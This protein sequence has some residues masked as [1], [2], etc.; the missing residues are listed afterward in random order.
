M[1]RFEQMHPIVSFIY[2]M[3]AIFITMFTNNP[4]ITITSFIGSIL[5]DISLRG[6]KKSIIG[7][8]KLLPIMLLVVILNPVFNSRGVTILFY[9]NGNPFTLEALLYGANAAVMIFGVINWFR[10]YS[11]VFTSDKF[12]YLFGK[13][14]PKFSLV[15]ALVMSFIPRFS[16]K[17]K[18]IDEAQKALGVYQSKSFTDRLR[19]RFRIL[20]ILIT[21]S[22]ETSIETADSMKA[23]GY[24]LFGRSSYSIFKFIRN[25][26]WL[27][28]LFILFGGALITL[29]SLN[30]GYFTFYP[31]ISTLFPSNLSIYLYILFGLFV[32]IG[33][34]LELK[35]DLL[36]R[37]L[38]QKI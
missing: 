19:N 38:K 10:C 28:I 3:L 34:A 33:P 13:I 22:L 1:K 11:F 29:L 20:S 6:F 30:G 23:R 18:E 5:F 31:S 35:E 15:L 21:Y 4:I 36:W 27:L 37:Y 24:G 25:D 12:I 14:V 16:K 9:L 17:F 26:L 32:L 8:L 7:F 2:F